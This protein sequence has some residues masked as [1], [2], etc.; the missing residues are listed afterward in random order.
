MPKE[1]LGVKSKI[2]CIKLRNQCSCTTTSTNLFYF[3]RL[4]EFH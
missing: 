2:L 1:N 4:E 3:I